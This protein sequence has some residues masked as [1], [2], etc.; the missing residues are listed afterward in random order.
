MHNSLKNINNM[1]QAN[2]GN[3]VPLQK[4]LFDGI[5]MTRRKVTC[6]TFPADLFND[7]V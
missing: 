4:L 3:T 5:K 2:I 1:F 7:P 6:F